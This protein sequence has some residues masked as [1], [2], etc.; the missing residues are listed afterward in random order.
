M[1]LIAM[2]GAA[3]KVA[4]RTVSA[5]RIVAGSP[6]EKSGPSV[7]PAN[8]VFTNLHG[9]CFHGS[10]RSEFP[11]YRIPVPKRLIV[12]RT[13]YYETDLVKRPRSRN[14]QTQRLI[15][16]PRQEGWSRSF[17]SRDWK[18]LWAFAFSFHRVADV[19]PTPDRR[20][21]AGHAPAVSPRCLGR[22][23]DADADADGP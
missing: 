21:R 6:D 4:L 13:S 8:L 20:R 7:L 10:P 15:F 17:Q 2:P 23:D 1:M 18:E 5:R 12:V 16:T 22:G 11:D 9:A 3:R 19:L 14:T